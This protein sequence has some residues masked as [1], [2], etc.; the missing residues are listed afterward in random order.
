[1]DLFIAVLI[2][3]GMITSGEQA[4]E[5]MIEQ[6]M[7]AIEQTAATEEFQEYYQ[8]SQ[9]TKNGVVQWDIYDQE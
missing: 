6:N 8:E 1:M 2:Y 4:T 5:Q 9:T 3:L 7:D